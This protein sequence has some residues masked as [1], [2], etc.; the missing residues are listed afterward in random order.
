MN[1]DRGNK[2][3]TLPFARPAPD[4]EGGKS[5]DEE[6]EAMLDIIR[7]EPAINISKTVLLHRRIDSGSYQVDAARV[8]QRLLALENR[9]QRDQDNGGRNSASD[10]KSSA[11]STSRKD[12]SNR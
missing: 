2:G 12:S 3:D 1:E 8:A 11:S 10:G 9:L 6:R 7:Q 4:G 5:A